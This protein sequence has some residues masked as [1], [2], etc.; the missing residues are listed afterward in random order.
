MLHHSNIL[1]IDDEDKLRGLLSRLISLEGFHVTEAAD[2]KAAMKK[3]EQMTF[4][5]IICD[6]KLPDA[7][8]IELTQKIKTAYPF[9]EVI[10]LTAFGEIHDGVQAM[11]NGAFDYLV[12]G[13]DNDK[14]IPLLNRAAEKAHMQLRIFQLEKKIT[15]QYSFEN[16]IGISK[17]IQ[18][19]IAL[20]KR[21]AATDASVLLTGE[22][23]TGKE[24][25][26]QSIH[27][28]SS[29]KNKNFVAVN[30][31]ALGREILESELFGYKAGAFTG[32]VKDKKGLFEEANEGTI[33][34]DE[35]GE[36]SLDLQTK[37]LRVLETNE[38]IKVGDTKT[39][40]VNTRLITATNRNLQ[41][42]VDAGKFRSDLYYRIAVFQIQLPALRERLKDIE[43]LAAHFIK[44]FAAV[45]NKPAPKMSP[46][47]IDK[48]KSHQWKGNIRELKNILER[49]VILSNS[50]ELSTDDLPLEIALNNGDYG[51]SS[52]DLS[53]MEKNHIQK[54][55]SHTKG[56][57]A[58]AA[59][60]LNI[61]IATLYRKLEEYKIGN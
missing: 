58:E 17:Q 22:T 39:I 5:V 26:A 20:A 8:G 29:R 3:L 23:G 19:A 56:N 40:K 57:K 6:V 60:L 2:A 1:I 32:A 42:E 30:C 50:D 59:R 9:S 51:V 45:T 21:V 52:F 24:V 47:F 31:A 43:L 7:N 49:A 48:L 25:F 37:L 53:L 36:M 18:E 10:V 38:F 12:K 44:R 4:Q 11:K 41:Q 54:V 14:I 16:I 28:N 35:I 33:F 55:L 61:G 15:D 27:Y 13:D 34:L 46:L